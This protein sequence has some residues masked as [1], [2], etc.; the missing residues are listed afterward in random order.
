MLPYYTRISSVI[1]WLLTS[2]VTFLLLMEQQPPTP[3]FPYIDTLIHASLFA[4]LMAIGYAAYAAYAQHHTSLYL[5]LISYGVVTEILQR[6]YTR[7][8]SA[9]LYKWFAD[10]TGVLLCI[11]I[12]N[13]LK[14]PRQKHHVR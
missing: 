9:S 1:F 2:L 12:I 14:S 3:L 7:T 4:T 6:A 8:R 10:I 13:K 11:L 5:G